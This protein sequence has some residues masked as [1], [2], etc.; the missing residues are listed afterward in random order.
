MG[1]MC[2]LVYGTHTP[3][4]A[5]QQCKTNGLY[6]VHMICLIKVC[7]K[8]PFENLVYQ[9]QCSVSRRAVRCLQETAFILKSVEIVIALC[10]VMNSC[11]IVHLTVVSISRFSDYCEAVQREDCIFYCEFQYFNV[12]VDY[13]V[14]DQKLSV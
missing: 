6:G 7:E 8:C 14:V 9:T 1:I 2:N 11:L 3:V 10:T 5:A 13:L 4:I 12:T